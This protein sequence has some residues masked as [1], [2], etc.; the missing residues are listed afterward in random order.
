M[1]SATD[2]KAVATKYNTTYAL[3]I[4]G[5]LGHDNKLFDRTCQHC[6]GAYSSYIIST[7]PKCS[8]PLVY[9]TT[10]A[11]KPMAISEGTIY[12]SQGPKTEERDR[13]AISN[14]KNGLTPLYR[15]KIFAF[16]DDNGVL[17]VPKDHQ[18]MRSGAQ[19]EVTIVNHQ[20]IPSGPFVT[21]KYGQTIEI[22]LMVYEQDGDTVKILRG[23]QATEATTPVQINT[24]D[25]TVPT[26]TEG[27]NAE[28]VLLSAR[29]EALTEAAAAARAVVQNPQAQTA[30][31]DNTV[32]SNDAM[33]AVAEM[34]EPPFESDG[35]PGAVSDETD[36][37]RAAS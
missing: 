35:D 32:V 24:A 19:V 12:L 15:F 36:P 25:A 14:R 21:Q 17:G 3:R 18:N 29:I 13:K 1:T 20:A 2:N 22:M 10:D 37:F 23:A 31:P 8:A 5:N 16:A 6:K 9:I 33:Q 27:I 4:V 26:N 30:V 7:C 28:L 34:E 11:G